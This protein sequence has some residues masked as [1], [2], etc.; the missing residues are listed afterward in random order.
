MLEY[1][2]HDIPW[3]RDTSHMNP[4]IADYLRMSITFGEGSSHERI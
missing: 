1:K 4:D 2:V 3:T